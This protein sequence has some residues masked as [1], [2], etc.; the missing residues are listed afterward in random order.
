MK[1]IPRFL[2]VTSLAASSSLLSLA[3]VHAAVRPTEESAPKLPEIWVKAGPRER[4]KA[5]RA[6]EV[7]ADRL[8]AERI[9]GVQ[10]DADTTVA[11]LAMS[12]EKIASAVQASLVGSLIV[13][14]PSILLTGA[15]RS[16]RP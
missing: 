15:W 1:S 8:L 9:Y 16:S 4:L 3:S 13:G 6:A 7:D 10:V 12:D 14:S 11:D 2:L 5:T